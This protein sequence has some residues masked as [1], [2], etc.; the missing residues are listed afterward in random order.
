MSEKHLTELPWKT[1][2]IK[3]KL[4]DTGLQK[5]LLAY[6]KVDSSKAPGLALSA[7][8]EVSEQAAKHKKANPT[9]KEVCAYLEEVL[10][11]ATKTKPGLTLLAKGEEPKTE[12]KEKPK[13]APAEEPEGEAEGTDLKGRLI[14]SLK[15]VKASEG[16]DS[17][18]FVAC[19]AK[20]WYGVLLAKSPGEHIGVAHKKELTERTKA[21]RFVEGRCLFEKEAHT[22]VVESVP[23]GLAKNLKKALKEYTGLLYKVRVR[24]V[25]GKVV[26]DADTEVDPDEIVKTPP[27]PAPKP[28][29]SPVAKAESAPREIPLS[30]YLRGLSDLRIARDNAAKELQKLQEAILAKAQDE[31]FYPDVQAKSQKLFEYL[32]PIDDTVVNKLDDAGKCTDPDMQLVLNQ[33]LRALIQKQLNSLRTHAL[34]SF[35]EKNPFGKFII[36]Q[37]LEVTLSALDNKL[38]Q[39]DV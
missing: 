11:E 18:A 2:V 5:A 4:K 10:K 30:V 21:T 17:I 13:V 27:T 39:Y 23:A 35:V 28:P 38:S 7:L 24:D 29:Q 32:A 34:A 15:K 25:E 19:V 12:A 16:K 14:N 26:A 3:T 36:K 31:P 6:S 9:N 22:F 8:Q 1:L 33:Q 37:A 20:P